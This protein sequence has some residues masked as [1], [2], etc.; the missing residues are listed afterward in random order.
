MTHLTDLHPPAG[1][2]EGE[3][4]SAIDSG[5]LFKDQ[6]LGLISEVFF[7]MFPHRAPSS[8]VQGE[9]SIEAS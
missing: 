2:T 5:I 6:G 8:F 3:K 7:S 9:F 1:V 4:T